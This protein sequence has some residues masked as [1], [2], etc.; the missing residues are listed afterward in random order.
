[1]RLKRKILTTCKKRTNELIGDC[2]VLRIL[3]VGETG[4]GKSTLVNNLLRVNTAEEGHSF[5]SKTTSVTKYSVNMDGISI[6]IY[7]TPG[8]G[9]SRCNRD[10]LNLQTMKAVLDG[11]KIHL[12]VYCMKLSE[13]RMRES[14]IHTFQE[15]TKIGVNWER[16]VIALTFADNLSVPSA[17]RKEHGF[18]MECFFNQRVAELGDCIRR[19]LT[20]QVR[21]SQE[22]ARN[23][24]CY[25]TTDNPE[26]PLVNEEMWYTPLWLDIVD[27]LSPAAKMRF[28]EI[29]V[30][31]LERSPS[32]DAPAPAP[33]I[34]P[35]SDPSSVK[36]VVLEDWRA[37]SSGSG[38]DNHTVSYNCTKQSWQHFLSPPQETRLLDIFLSAAGVNVTV[39]AGGV[40]VGAVTGSVVGG[41]AGGLVGGPVGVAVGIG[42]GGLIGG[43]TGGSAASV[44]GIPFVKAVFS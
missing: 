26:E 6:E 40:A 34:Q 12:V 35:N 38:S 28:L 22:Q 4:T 14:I 13:T 37:D 27:I 43:A 33:N 32:A 42:L 21:I 30:K 18:K 29:H 23:I 3:V 39:A 44:L 9:D 11:D 20:E 10:F 16:T 31:N 7:D 41:V 19:A 5:Y 15:Y 36:V 8:L 25:P 2:P 24:K 17:K 1:M